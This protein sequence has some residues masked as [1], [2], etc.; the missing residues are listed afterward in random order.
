MI[1]HCE[2]HMRWHEAPNIGMLHTILPL[3]DTS[4]GALPPQLINHGKSIRRPLE[5]IKGRNNTLKSLVE[6]GAGPDC[7]RKVIFLSVPYSTGCER[8]APPDSIST[9]RHPLHTQ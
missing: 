9:A 2:S 7:Y 8:I 3:L 6:D 4:N 1:S 5:K